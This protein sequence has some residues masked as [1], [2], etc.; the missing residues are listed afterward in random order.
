MVDAAASVNEDRAGSLQFRFDNEG[1]LLERA[2]QRP[3][4]G[5]GRWGRSRVYDESGSDIGVTDGRWTITL[6]QFG[7]L[8]FL[9]EFGLLAWPV[10]WAASAL[11]FAESE[12]DSV[13]LAAL[14][15]IIAINMIDLLPNASLSPWTWLLAGAL[16]GRAEALR[17]ASRQLR[18]FDRLAGA[19]L[20]A[21]RVASQ[22]NSVP[23]PLRA[24]QP[25]P[26]QSLTEFSAPRQF[27][28]KPLPSYD[29]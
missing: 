26:H 1:R 5:W 11:R 9:V 4:F 21:E 10:F 24:A 15:L 2:S 25:D 28:T 20:G 13:F 14:A 7:I 19:G 18:R 16:L 17:S 27:N 6:G 12:R 22:R 8:G 23:T 29:K 3:L